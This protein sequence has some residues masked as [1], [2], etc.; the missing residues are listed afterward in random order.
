M[1]S[2]TFYTEQNNINVDK[3]VTAVNILPNFLKLPDIFVHHAMP[4]YHYF[5][6]HSDVHLIA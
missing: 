4:F 2:Y 3:L 5:I 6:I 1:Q